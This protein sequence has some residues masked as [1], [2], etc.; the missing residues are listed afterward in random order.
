LSART[1]FVIVIAYNRALVQYSG[2]IFNDPNCKATS[3]G[4][5]VV[6]LVGYNN[7]E[8]SWLMRNSWGPKW[9]EGGYFRFT[10]SDYNVCG[11]YDFGLI[12]TI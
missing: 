8:S 1:T 3:L 10:K 5:H 11:I 2:G 6:P 7:N 12:F 9:G 4:N